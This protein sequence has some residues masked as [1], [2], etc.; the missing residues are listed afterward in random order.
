LT[1]SDSR[2]YRRAM[3][4]DPD[5]LYCT[6]CGAK[7]FANRGALNAHEQVHRDMEKAMGPDHTKT[8]I[9]V[10]NRCAYCDDG[11]LPCIQGNPNRCGNPRAR[12][13]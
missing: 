5:G 4:T 9:F 2:E 8:G 3:P 7:R 11:R 6:Y 1:K 10:Y 12:N 13:D